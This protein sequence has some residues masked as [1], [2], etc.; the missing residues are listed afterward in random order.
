MESAKSAPAVDKAHARAR[1][2]REHCRLASGVAAPDDDDF[3]IA[4]TVRAS[5]WVAA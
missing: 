4:C 5:S 2:A 3:Q 1:K